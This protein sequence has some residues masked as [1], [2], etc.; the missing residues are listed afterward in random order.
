MVFAYKGNESFCKAD[1]TDSEGTLVDNGLDAVVF[2]KI[3]TSEPECTHQERELFL[4]GC[5]LEIEPLTKLFCRNV[6]CPV[7]FFEEFADSLLLVLNAHAL[8]GESYDIDGSEGK[9]TPCN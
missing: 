7:E 8:D 4:E 9:V 6:H 1:E 3:L 5:F 2:L